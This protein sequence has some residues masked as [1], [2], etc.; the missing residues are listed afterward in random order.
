LEFFTSE[1]KEPDEMLLRAMAQIGIQL[2][3][4]FERK[5]AETEL[6]AAKEAAHRAER[7]YRERISKS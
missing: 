3:Q 4:I 6:E 2:G 7:E 5:R 1:P